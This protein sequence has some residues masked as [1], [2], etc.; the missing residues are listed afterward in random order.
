[1]GHVSTMANNEVL[2][3]VRMV[4]SLLAT[5][6]LKVHASCK[7]LIAEFPG[8]SWDPKAA[9]KGQDAPLHV[10]DHCLD[11]GRYILRTAEPAWRNRLCEPVIPSYN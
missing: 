1:M 11:A 9:Q 2:P 5:H 6:R 10:D 3:G 7:A 8:Y 4:A